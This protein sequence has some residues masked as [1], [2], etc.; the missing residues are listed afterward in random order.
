MNFLLPIIPNLPPFCNPQIPGKRKNHP[1]TERPPLGSPSGRAG[2]PPLSMR[3]CY[4]G[5]K[6][7]PQGVTRFV[8]GWWTNAYGICVRRAGACPRRPREFTAPPTKFHRPKAFPLGGRWLAA[9]ETDEGRQCK[10][11]HQRQKSNVSTPHQSKIKDFCQLL[12]KEKPNPLRHGWRRATSPI[13]R[14]KGG[15]PPLSMTRLI[16]WW[17]THT[18]GGHPV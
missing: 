2:V 12:P 13:G 10:S 18:I 8:T 1:K 5:S 11:N 7:P 6:P 16:P 14:G 9:G 15:V 4:P 17:E 3:A